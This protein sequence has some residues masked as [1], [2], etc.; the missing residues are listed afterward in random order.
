MLLGVDTLN[1]FHAGF[2]RLS[3]NGRS[4]G[5]GCFGIKGRRILSRTQYI[6]LS[7]GIHFDVRLLGMSGSRWS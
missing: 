3:S 6:V 5:L 2:A 7:G 4:D 1:L